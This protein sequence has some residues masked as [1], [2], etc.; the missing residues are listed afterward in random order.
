M[1]YKERL[2]RY[3]EIRAALPDLFTNPPD[4]PVELITGAEEIRLIEE[5]AMR[6]L[7]AQG[8]PPEWGRLGVVFEDPYSVTL[9]D[10]VRKPGGQ[11][12]TYSRRINPGNAPGVV[13]L[14]VHPDGLILIRHFR[15]S[16]RGWHLEFPRGFGTPGERSEDDARREL[17][18]EIGAIADT[19]TS[20]GSMYPDT[21]QMATSVHLYLAEISKYQLADKEE[22]IGSIQA[23]S[24]AE[25]ADLIRTDTITDGFTIA[26][27]T[28]AVL[29]GLLPHAI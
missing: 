5:E 16:T 4:A 12:G 29:R 21:G 7:A 2:T 17:L 8:N 18:E 19:L 28:R 23:V 6:R 15:H 11:R 27:Y 24:S 3:R 14:P 10:A 9:R 26:A 13:V 25:L 22:G 1:N 20:L